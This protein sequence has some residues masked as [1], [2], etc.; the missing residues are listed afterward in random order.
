MEIAY[1]LNYL[2]SDEIDIVSKLLNEIFA[3]LTA[4][5]NKQ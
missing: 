3:M 2:N 4:M 5:M 1:R